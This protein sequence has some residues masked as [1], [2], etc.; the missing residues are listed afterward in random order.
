[1]VEN[2]LKIIANWILI[3][4][5][6]I[7]L[8]CLVKYYKHTGNTTILFSPVF[9]LTYGCALIPFY[10]M[11]TIMHMYASE[12]KIGWYILLHSAFSHSCMYIA[13]FTTVLSINVIYCT[14][15]SDMKFYCIFTFTSVYIQYSIFIV[16]R[17]WDT[18]K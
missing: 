8:K 9:D 18:Q 2:L 7:L 5:W 14:Q 3:Q 1:M 4:I 17:V 12:Y 15:F 11:H 13:Q 16:K 6:D 10:E